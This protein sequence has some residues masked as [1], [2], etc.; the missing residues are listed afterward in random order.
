MEESKKRILIA[1]DN[2]VLA[3]VIRFNL[4]R[5]GFEVTLAYDGDA[6]IDKLRDDR[7]D[8]LITDYQMPIADGAELCRFVQRCEHLTGMPIIMCSAKGLELNTEQLHDEWNIS[9]LLHKPFSV[10]EMIS[11]VHSLLASPLV[12]NGL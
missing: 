9:R 8:L 6:A 12:A 7:F 3:D 4:E 2:R 11:L 10:R 5:G 1:E